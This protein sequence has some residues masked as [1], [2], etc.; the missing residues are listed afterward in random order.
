VRLH[1]SP[2]R[3]TVAPIQSVASSRRKLT[4]FAVHSGRLPSERPAYSTQW[5]P[6]WHWDELPLAD[7]NHAMPPLRANPAHRDGVL[8]HEDLRH[9]SALVEALL[10]EDDAAIFCLGAYAGAVPEA[11]LRRISAD[12]TI[13]LAR[14][15]RGTTP[16]CIR[17]FERKRRGPDGTNSHAYARDKGR[18]RS[19]TR[20]GVPA[21]LPKSRTPPD[22]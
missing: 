15:L 3:T 13:E 16:A 14:V 11:E 2:P 8:L 10:Y 6:C 21:H 9:Y 5:R 4:T 7:A 1:R 22:P 20:G 18:L 17:I 12:Y 19:T